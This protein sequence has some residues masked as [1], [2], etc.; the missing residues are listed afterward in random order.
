MGPILQFIPKIHTEGYK[1][2]AIFLF[3]SFIG[4]RFNTAMGWIL[5]IL[6]IACTLFFRNPTRIAP[7]NASAILS[8]A[9][10]I[11]TSIT[12]LVPPKELDMGDEE[13][14]RI[15]TFLSVFDVHVNRIPI[16]GKIVKTHYHPGKFI[17]AA[18]DKSSD[19]NERQ[20]LTIDTGT[21][22]IGVA[23]I[24]GLIARRIVCDVKESQMVVSG[25]RFGIIR[26]GSR[27]DIFLPKNYTILVKLGQRMV[28]GESVIAIPQV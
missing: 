1:F 16:A 27:V 25:E 5:L 23:Q 15:S 20:L 22:R 7:D 2:I 6:T 14:I 13:V 17:S 4:F 21:N 28:G 19:E 9:D 11:I 18:M 24:A 3:L 26:F 8:A 10:G 12:T